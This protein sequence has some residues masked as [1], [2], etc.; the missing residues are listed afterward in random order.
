M[1]I[2]SEVSNIRQMENGALQETEYVTTQWVEEDTTKELGLSTE[3]KCRE[4]TFTGGDQLPRKGQLI[5]PLFTMLSP[6]I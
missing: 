3:S 6:P 5:L 1:P 4:K 2:F